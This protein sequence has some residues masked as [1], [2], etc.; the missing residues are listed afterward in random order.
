MHSSI[1]GS[2]FP[3]YNTCVQSDRRRT[4]G[5]ASF[6]LLIVNTGTDPL[7][8]IAGSSQ[9]CGEEGHMKE[10]EALEIWWMCNQF[11]E[12]SSLPQYVVPYYASL[13]YSFI[14]EI[15]DQTVICDGD[16]KRPVGYKA[17]D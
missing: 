12:S 16:K 2:I 10:G 7:E 5:A 13:C 1:L 17:Q 4:V 3:C 8:A 11:F 14:V 6:E 15:C 9:Q